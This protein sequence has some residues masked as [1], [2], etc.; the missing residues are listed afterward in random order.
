VGEPLPSSQKVPVLKKLIQSAFHKF[1]FRIVRD[2]SLTDASVSPPAY[3]LEPF[4]SL[5]KRYGFDPK[6]IIDVGANK[7]TWTRTALPF[8]PDADYTLVEP[9]DHLKVHIQDLLDRGCK[10]TWINAGVAD[11]SGTLP[12]TISYRDDSSTF[13]PTPV[14]AAAP[15]ISVRVT[16]LNEI[17]STASAPGPEMVKIDAE[18]FDLK[19]LAGASDLLG[20]TDVFFVEVTICCSGYENTIARVIHR[21]DEAGYKVVDFTDI[22]RSPK[23]GVLWLCELAFLRNDC[24]LFRAV[25]SYE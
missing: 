18:G 11:Q 6:Q 5:L 24:S 20:R 14:N 9:Q 21:M 4:F 15:R 8:F 2:G 1:G 19:V 25:T 16:T 10:I 12:F 7:G 17:I 22:N 23:Y 3:G 13:V